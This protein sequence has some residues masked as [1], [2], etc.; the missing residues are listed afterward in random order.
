MLIAGFACKLLVEI[1]K[2]LLPITYF[3]ALTV[4]NKGAVVLIK[5]DITES[6]FRL[7]NRFKWQAV[8]QESVKGAGGSGGRGVALGGGGDGSGRRG[9][10]LGG[11][12][13]FGGRRGGSGGRGWLE[14]RE[15]KG[16][17]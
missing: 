4:N 13:G 3:V 7:A 5:M 6:D 8:S 1:G 11:G 17:F 16:E 9:V 12:G 15:G 14:G 2:H 10:A